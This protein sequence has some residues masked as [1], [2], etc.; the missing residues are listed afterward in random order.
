MFYIIFNGNNFLIQIIRIEQ[1]E[2]E[3]GSLELKVLH[4]I[5]SNIV[6]NIQ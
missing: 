4:T 3:K 2:M 6:V 1:E 5:L